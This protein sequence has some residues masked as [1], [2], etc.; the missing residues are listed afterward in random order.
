MLQKGLNQLIELWNM[1]PSDEQKK[2]IRKLRLWYSIAIPVILIGIVT[3]LF[4]YFHST[5]PS[6][7]LMMQLQRAKNLA[8]LEKI[9]RNSTVKLS[10]DRM[11]EVYISCA[12]AAFTDKDY[13]ES[14][15]L[16]Q[17]VID[18]NSH[19]ELKASARY[20]MANACFLSGKIQEGVQHLDTLLRSPEIPREFKDKALEMRQYVNAEL[21]LRK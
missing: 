2:I 14:C 3:G 20:E 16:L 18:S 21:G 6:R 9:L 7:R 15:K 4:F 5:M 19:P 12:M 10:D 1:E 11:A 13:D 17:K 8:Q